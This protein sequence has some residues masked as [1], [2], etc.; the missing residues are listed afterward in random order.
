MTLLLQFIDEHPT[1]RHLPA[2]SR[3]A[4]GLPAA[5]GEI[6]Y[7]DDSLARIAGRLGES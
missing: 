4:Q 1:T 2:C 7:L 3:A 6:S 5:T